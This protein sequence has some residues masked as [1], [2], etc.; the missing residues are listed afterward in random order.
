M[1]LC[2]DCQLFTCE[3]CHD[4]HERSHLRNMIRFNIIQ[5][6]AKLPGIAPSAPCRYCAKDAK[7]RWQCE[8]CDMA[9]C[10]TCVGHHDR[11]IEFFSEHRK[12]DPDSRAFMAIYPPYW[13]TTP[14]WII[15]NCRCLDNG[16]VGCSHCDRCHRVVSCGQRFYF[17]RSCRVEFGSSQDI[18][19]ECFE[20]D[21][22]HRN[23]HQFGTAEIAYAETGP[24][25][26][27]DAIKSLWA[28]SECPEKFP[29][30]THH[31]HPHL[32]LRL[33][34]TPLIAE[35]FRRNS[36][37]KCYSKDIQ[38]ASKQ[39]PN[40]L[41][42]QCGL[43]TK[44]LAFDHNGAICLREGCDDTFCSD[45]TLAKRTGHRHYLYEFT[46]M[47]SPMVYT[48]QITCNYCSQPSFLAVCQGLWCS[49]CKNHFICLTCMI[50]TTK[51]GMPKIEA[52]LP[53]MKILKPCKVKT[54]WQFYLM[55]SL[56]TD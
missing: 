51:T 13:S 10:R 36:Y 35:L 16:K 43:C 40:A 47:R 37:Q 4:A 6:M 27:N 45:C 42:F 22:E 14:S 9:L 53:H 48:S 38:Q 20:E 33:I 46:I 52:G 56:S 8:R 54:G 41:P 5:W 25:N 26:V 23:R 29:E 32:H 55:E 17:C 19:Q 18:C 11:R 2:V 1:F 21:E 12:L 39:Y 15:P 3:G 34:I 49:D 44:K 7:V 24:D 30:G 31:M 28:C 50:K